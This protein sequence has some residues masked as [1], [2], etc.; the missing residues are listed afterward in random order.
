MDCC[1]SELYLSCISLL[2]IDP[3]CIILDPFH[4]YVNER[5]S[6]NGSSNWLSQTE[7]TFKNLLKISRHNNALKGCY[8]VANCL[9]PG[10]LSKGQ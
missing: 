5:I 7:S 2:S 9:I 4:M 8:F 1:W 10:K 3:D 6:A